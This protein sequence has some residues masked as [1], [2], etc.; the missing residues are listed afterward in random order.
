ML[1]AQKRM[2]EMGLVHGTPWL[3]PPRWD[4]HD[5]RILFHLCGQAAARAGGL[6][7]PLRDVQWRVLAPV[8]PVVFQIESELGTFD[9]VGCPSKAD[10]PV[11]AGLPVWQKRLW[12][13]KHLAFQEQE[14]HE[15]IIGSNRGTVWVSEVD[16][17]H[18]SPLAKL[19]HKT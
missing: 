1:R 19:E 2:T 15:M 11:D 17:R 14:Q 7:R 18:P 12:E 8:A 3:R 6:A 9:P 4:D 13:R 16:L 10:P 5:C